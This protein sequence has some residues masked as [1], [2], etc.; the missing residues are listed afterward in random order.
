M[1]REDIRKKWKEGKSGVS[2]DS[3]KKRFDNFIKQQEQKEI[4]K[5]KV[6]LSDKDKGVNA[7]IGVERNVFGSAPKQAKT[8]NKPVTAVLNTEDIVTKKFQ[9]NIAKQEA[10][11]EKIEQTNKLFQKTATLSEEKP[12]LTKKAKVDAGLS[13][14]ELDELSKLD[15]KGR[16]D[17][18]KGRTED[19]W[20]QAELYAEEVK[21]RELEKKVNQEEGL[22]KVGNAALYFGNEFAKNTVASFAQIKAT[23]DH[24]QGRDKNQKGLEKAQKYSETVSKIG[25][26]VEDKY[27]QNLGMAFEGV[28]Q[29]MPQV[30][31]GA[32]GT[33]ALVGGF[34]E[35]SN[36]YNEMT[37]EDPTN[38]TKTLTTALLKGTAA[39]LLE[40]A[41]GLFGKSKLDDAVIS[42]IASI[43]GKNAVTKWFKQNA[44]A[45]GYDVGSEVLEEQLENMAGYVIDKIVNDKNI[46]LEQLIADAQATFKQ[47]SATTLL[48]SMLGLGGNTKAEV[49]NLSNRYD[50]I[51]QAKVSTTQKMNLKELARKSDTTNEQLYNETIKTM[52]ENA[53][54]DAVY[55][56]ILKNEETAENQP[57]TIE[58]KEVLNPSQ[59]TTLKQGETAKNTISEQPL[60]NEKYMVKMPNSEYKYEKSGNKNEDLLDESMSKVFNNSQATKKLNSTLKT[61]MKDKNVSIVFDSNIRDEKGNIIDGKYENGKITINPNSTKAFEYIATH[62]LTHAIGTKE[63][64]KM[65]DNY[66]KSNSE[67]NSKVE[68]LLKNYNKSELTEEALADVSAELFGTQEFIANVK[69]TNPN[70][71][72][73]IY[74]EI[75][76]LWHQFRGYKNQNQFVEDLYNKWTAAYNSKEELNQTTRNLNVG[77]KGYENAG[78]EILKPENGQ[79]SRKYRDLTNNVRKA[80]KMAIDGKS[81]EEILKAT[82]G[83]WTKNT[84]NNQV[85][86]NISDKDIEVVKPLQ[87]NSETTLGEIIDHP[88]L[89]FYYPELKNMAV[90]TEKVEGGQAYYS[91]KN[92]NIHIDNNEIRD[93]NQIKFN[94]IHELQHAIQ[95]IEGTLT[96]DGY[97]DSDASY[98]NNI[99]EIEADDQVERFIKERKGEKV[100]KLTEVNKKRPTHSEYRKKN[101]VE[102]FPV[103]MYNIINGYKGVVNQDETNKRYLNNNSMSANNISNI[104][105]NVDT[106]N[107]R[108]YSQNTE[109]TN[110]GSKNGNYLQKAKKS[111]EG[112]EESSSFNLQKLEERVSGDDLLDA[113]DFIEE[114]KSVGAEI[115]ENGYVTVYHQT[116]S[117]NANKIKQSGKM[118]AKEDGIFF[119]TS[120]NAQ[121]SEGRGTEKIKFKIPA[122]ILQLDDIFDDNADVRIPLKSKNEVIDVS[123]YIVKD[124]DVKQQQ[125]EIIKKYNP[126]LDDYH[127]GIRTIDDIKTYQEALNDD[128]DG[129]IQDLTPDFKADELRKALETGE[130]TV[131]SSYPIEQ[132]VFVTPSK[133]EAGSY[134]G[135]INKVYSKKIKLLDVAWIDTLQGQYAKVEDTKVVKDNKGRTL[136]KEQQDYFKDSKVRDENGNLLEV[137]HGTKTK[138]INIF[139]YDPNRQT[140]TDYGKAYYFTTDYDKAQGYQYDIEKDP[141]Y[142]EF[143]RQDEEWKEKVFSAKNE[144]ERLKLIKEWSNW[145]KENNVMK[146]LDNEEMTP[147]RLPDGET[148]KLYLNIKKPY[149]VDAKGQNYYKVYDK[150]FKEA[151]EN[152]NDG[153]IVKNVI[154]NPKGEPRPIDVYIAFNENQIKNVDNTNPTDNPD[155]RYSKQNADWYDYVQDTF[156][157]EGTRTTKESILKDSDAAI[158]TEDGYTPTQKAINYEQRQKNNFKRNMSDMLGISRFNQNNKTIF[159]DAIDEMQKEYNATGTI[160]E[161]TKNRVFENMYNGLIKEDAA[162][163]NENKELKNTIRTTT[164]YV[165]DET[166]ADITD[167]P[168]FKKS[169]FGNIRI[170]NDKTDMPIDTFYQ[171]LSSQRPDL[172][173]PEIMTTGEQLV[174]IAEVSKSI[175]KSERNLAAYNDNMEAAEYKKWARNEFDIQTARLQSQFDFVKKYNEAKLKEFESKN[176]P[177]SRPAVEEIKAI[178]QN[179][180]EIRK[181]VEKQER[182]LLLTDREKAIVNRLLNDEMD[183]S[184]IMPGYN[185]EAIIKSYYARQQLDYLDKEVK[186]YKQDK[187]Q[188][189]YDM[190]EYLISGIKDWKDKKIGLQYS[191]ETAQRNIR[192]IMTEREAKRIN[193][194]IFDPILENTANQVRFIKDYN[195]QIEALELD[196]KAKYDWKVENE[197]DIKIDEATLAQLLIEKKIDK[198]YL[199]EIG[200]DVEKIT[201]AANT[202]SRILN[203]V[204]DMM[205]DV[206]VEFGYAPVERRKNYFPHFIENKPDTLFSKIANALNFSTEVA[207]LSTDIAGRTESF[208]PGRAFNRNIL[209]RTTEKTE[210]NALDMY[211]QGASDI[212]YHTADIQKL[213][214][215]SESIRDNYKDV[216]VQKKILEIQENTELTEDERAE[217]IKEIK[218]NIKTP[219]PKLVEWLDE[220]TNLLANKKASGDRQTEK[221]LNRQ[222]YTT[223]QEIEGKIASNLIG[224][225]LSVSLT[226][227][228][229]LFQAMGTTKV[230]DLLIGMVKT[231]QN[232]IN[233]YNNRN[234]N[235][236]DMSDFL[237]SRR[238]NE[239]LQK[240]TVKQNISNALGTPMELIDNFV[241]ESI[242]RAKYRENVKKGM[243]HIEAL[244][245]ADTYTRNLMAD[246][247]K[248]ALPTIF[249]RKNPIS[250]LMTSFQVEPNNIISNYF[251]DMKADADTKTQLANQAIKLS[252]SSF[253]FNE[254]LK[255]IRGGSDVIPNP[256]G[257]ASKLIAL[258]MS[259]LNDDEEDDMDTE[260]VLM[261]IASDILGSV[262][263]GTTLAMIATAGGVEGLEETGKF[264]T[265]SA[266]PNISKLAGLNDEEVSKE[267]RNQVL[268]TELTKPLI[269][270]GLPT[271]GSQLSKTAKGIKAYVEG[272]SYSYNK[273]GERQLQFPIEKN[274]GNAVKATVFG[275][276]SLPGATKYI[277]EGFKSLNGKETEVYEQSSIDFDEF[278]AYVKYSK[279]EGVKKQDKINYIDQ[280]NLSS[281]DKW[282][283]YKHN[284]ISDT[285]RK[286]GTSQLSDAQY[287]IDNNLAS[288]EE[289]M[290]IYSNAEKNEV[291][292]PATETLEELKESG[293]SLKTYMEYKTNLTLGNRKKK[294]EYEKQNKM[295]VSKEEAEKK[296]TLSTEEKID[297]ISKY[298][299][300]EKA[301]LYENYIASEDTVYQHLKI[302]TGDN[303]RINSY[304]EYK[305]ADLDSDKKYDGTK[306]GKTV[307]GS[308]EKKLK[309]FL[310]NSKFSNIERIYLYGQ[311]YK[312]SNSQK[313]Q[314][315]NY[316]SNLGLTYEEEKE[317]WLDLSSNNVVEM[318][319]GSVKWK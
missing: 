249:A 96:I 280:M 17:A 95:D 185:K 37:L 302:L 312:L 62:E 145:H 110:Q 313:Q 149:I 212:I 213:R 223:M 287:I 75:K 246:R 296:K 178:Y 101:I 50:F 67:F 175:R 124:N 139:N 126:M 80:V 83:K 11:E 297:L 109:Y 51:D 122:E 4:Q 214:A 63:M 60:G 189:L 7:Q 103:A 236:V 216:E 316:I 6:E 102:K 206:Y 25:D 309:N 155:I 291:E 8:Y 303:V 252:V 207:E 274:I 195:S 136:T 266:L 72:Q 192:D 66:R 202:F 32:S 119:S 238:G 240:Q 132:G 108:R 41:L 13:Q 143:N 267:Y 48:M 248:G 205:D 147:E 293:L 237:T 289:Y 292:F 173:P 92:K 241:S 117:E 133:M 180:N 177:Y 261:G 211:L 218:D 285:E 120:K 86:F 159:N 221:D 209:K 156:G 85:M 210:Y 12:T 3:F 79:Y 270:L 137:Y 164:L 76:Y 97:G 275:K 87:K 158:F 2:S 22:S 99:L 284:I 65:V 227:I 277:D 283:L 220:Y 183:V 259:N 282:N 49:S 54:Q 118:S 258:A 27:I 57:S 190:S 299:D 23:A 217:K 36:T 39:G 16:F 298:S 84:E 187:K 129:E 29:Q 170:S 199:Q 10:Q 193:A 43:K 229:P 255:K 239:Q 91:D 265:S 200:A 232:D 162:F 168:V 307:P 135:N 243:E 73:K 148:K 272:G 78:K 18:L 194:E 242:V 111:T 169:M 52:Q 153:I 160:S 184:E 253:V 90:V 254:A 263:F 235:F 88:E 319:D 188:E 279:A 305:T 9:E 157:T 167:Y 150:Y 89:F 56:N 174:R 318:A 33:G 64:L 271:G 81:G 317:I 59:Q 115:D 127:T 182:N 31:L 219:L 165:S 46:T 24:I 74:N 172:F 301:A 47:T 69:N 123:Q 44:M 181:E 152:G 45:V 134:A 225:N 68:T 113:Q 131:Y 314:F 121:Q 71:F 264:M 93:I 30:L 14:K 70:L 125:L 112:L 34:S 142:I 226:N 98:L 15:R 234:D 105:K 26:T 191:R 58:N 251:K 104:Y 151:R 278:K 208:K 140:G 141:L 281:Q 197:K 21:N 315:Q 295:P 166:K 294:A 269:Y 114:V 144:K 308:A 260:E 82:N 262:P 256:I 55:E 138:G 196:K 161:E 244:K 20:L 222:M 300:K 201:K 179:R 311:K 276:Y 230:G 245:A 224:G 40:K 257:I 154:D 247:S 273:K 310:D 268:W 128:L 286:D 304:L 61:I 171:E 53:Y 106:N 204:V 107:N 290:K 42:D 77:L 228:A 94:L 163:Y 198:A 130:I 38:K 215:F 5:R 233:T 28:G 146:I 100:N 116:T 19:T 288:E 250:K 231:I 176:V 203:E 1:S 306:K 186:R 35:F